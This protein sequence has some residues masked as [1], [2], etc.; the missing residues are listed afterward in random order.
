M[1]GCEDEWTGIRIR[2]VGWHLV[3]A[4]FGAYGVERVLAKLGGG[5]ASS[6]EDEAE[7]EAEAETWLRCGGT[8]TRL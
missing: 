1:Q 6:G 2:R 5:V 3:V 8:G 7:A 4:S